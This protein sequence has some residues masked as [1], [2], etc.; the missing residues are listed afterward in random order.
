MHLI[1]IIWTLVCAIII[2]GYPFYL[3]NKSSTTIKTEEKN[4]TIPFSDTVELLSF[5]LRNQPPSWSFILEV[6][7]ITE[8]ILYNN[9][10]LFYLESDSYCLKL[11]L[12][13]ATMGYT[14]S[15]HKNT[16][17]VY[18]TFKSLVDDVSNFCVPSWHL[19]KLKILII[20]SH[21]KRRYGEWGLKHH[22]L[23]LYK[24]LKQADININNYEDVLIYFSNIAAID[25]KGHFSEPTIRIENHE[26]SSTG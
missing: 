17:K 19:S 15:I 4:N 7:Q 1:T 18:L 14:A 3:Y 5:D 9:P 10:I 8:D 26:L 12:N 22:K 13:N 25:F 6:P 23:S 2:I 16:G 24:E 21:D 20:K 11:P